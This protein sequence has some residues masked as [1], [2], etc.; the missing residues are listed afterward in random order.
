MAHQWTQNEHGIWCPACGELIRPEWNIPDDERELPE[1]CKTCGF[2]DFEEG[3][4]YFTAMGPPM[5]QRSLWTITCR[6]RWRERFT[7]AWMLIF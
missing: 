3:C 7:F 1:T 2:P 4:G 5:N 6:R